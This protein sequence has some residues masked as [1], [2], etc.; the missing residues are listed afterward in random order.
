MITAVLESGIGKLTGAFILKVFKENCLDE[1]GMR[2]VVNVPS[3]ADH[4]FIRLLW[5]VLWLPFECL[6]CAETMLNGLHRE[7]SFLLTRTLLSRFACLM[8]EKTVLQRSGSMESVCGSGQ[9]DLATPI[10]V[11]GPEPFTRP[12][13]KLGCL[14][15]SVLAC[16][17][18]S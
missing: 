9:L 3:L 12:T 5:N 18:F 14:Y 6:Q 15:V 2:R 17:L 8:H 1:K 11:K 7:A 10:M 13:T 4:L 16:C